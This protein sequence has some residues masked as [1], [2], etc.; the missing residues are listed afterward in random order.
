MACRKGEL[1]NIIYVSVIEGSLP[2]RSGNLTQKS[3]NGMSFFFVVFPMAFG[4]P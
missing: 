4:F 1:G 2:I 3:A